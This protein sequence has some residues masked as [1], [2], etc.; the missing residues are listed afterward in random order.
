MLGKRSKSNRLDRRQSCLFQEESL[1]QF[2]W[3]RPLGA[4]EDCRRLTLQLK[5]AK[6]TLW[7]LP[8]SLESALAEISDNP[9]RLDTVEF[10]GTHEAWSALRE[11][12]WKDICQKVWRRNLRKISFYGGVSDTQRGV[13][14]SNM[15]LIR[16]VEIYESRSH[17]RT[18]CILFQMCQRL[19][20]L[21]MFYCSDLSKDQA[22]ILLS[23]LHNRPA[24]RSLVLLHTKFNDPQKTAMRFC[25]ALEESASLDEAE[26]GHVE[27][28]TKILERDYKNSP[29]AT[30]LLHHEA[31]KGFIGLYGG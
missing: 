25:L 30:L 13:L 31:A 21:R 9:R 6:T 26:F 27:E 7:A 8:L 10:D 12:D 20:E 24:L 3:H 5:T 29:Y 18:L 23:M 17:D 16:S 11:S 15:P 2:Y 28:E 4:P 19:A 1:C 14:L 22:D